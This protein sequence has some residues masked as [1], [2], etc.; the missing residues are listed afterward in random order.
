[1]AI[2]FARIEFVKR[3]DGKNACAKAAYNSRSE[4]RFEGN[5][6]ANAR[7][8]DWS[9]KE[10][11]A[12]HGVLL[13]E[14][15]DPKFFQPSILWNAVETKETKSNAVVALD[16]VLALPDEK[17]LSLDDRVRLAET[18]V[19]SQFVSKGLAA[20]I[21][22]HA[23]EREVIIT[24]NNVELGLSR[25]SKGQFVSKSQDKVV[26]RLDSGTIISFDPREFTGYVEKDHNWHAH[27]LVTTRRFKPDGKE[28]DNHKARDLMPRLAYGK[29]VSGLDW[30]KLWGEH[31]NRYFEEK[32]F[33]F[34]VDPNGI[35]PQEHLGPRR[36]RARAFSLLEEQ[37]RRIETNQQASL[38]PSK[39]LE[40]L[41]ERKSLFTK[42]D[43]EQFFNKYVSPEQFELVNQAFWKNPDVVQLVDKRT[44]EL[45][46]KFTSQK[47]VEEEK[48]ILRLCDKIH[49]DQRINPQEDKTLLKDLTSE[50]IDAYHSIIRG[51]RLSLIQGYAG[52]G[53]SYL[54]KALQTTYE[55]A[56]YKVRAFG[57]DNATVS[58]L[59]EKGLSH[60][61]NIYRFLTAKYHDH[62]EILKGK[63]VWILDEA[64]KVG[65]RPLLE[66]LKQADK[67]KVKLILSGDAA[68]LS[69]VDR[70]GMFKTLCNKYGAQT[71]I[72]I[73]RQAFE[74]DRAISKDLATG[75]FGSAIDAL[76][77]DHKIRW[78]EDKHEAMEALITRWAQ[79][80]RYFPSSS[81]LLIAHS[82]AE[83]KVLNEM[84]RLIR[85]Q[86]GEIEEKEYSCETVKGTIYVSTG[87][88]LKLCKNDRELG[89]TNG[90]YG[91]LI[92]VSPTRFVVSLNLEKG[93]KQTVTFNPQEYNDFQL[94]Y[95][96]TYHK[97]QGKTV[98]RAYVLHSP[99]MNK[100]MFYVGLTRHVKDVQYF[101]SK[102]D[103]SCLSDLKWIAAR[104]DH[105]DLTVGYT[106][107]QEVQSQ[108]NRESKS[109]AIHH[110]K[111]SESVVDRLKGH[112]LAT[113]D[114]I[115]Q[116]A[117]EIQE[118]VSDRTP[119]PKFYKLQKP[120]LQTS[121][122][123]VEEVRDKEDLSKLDAKTIVQPILASENGRMINAA[124]KDFSF[125]DAPH[126]H[127]LLKSPTSLRKLEAKQQSIVQDYLDTL[128]RCG[129][130]KDLVEIESQS[131]ALE[132]RQSPHF[133]EWQESCGKRNQAA[134]KLVQ[135]IEDN[136]LKRLFGPK[137]VTF[138]QDEAHRHAQFLERAQV[139]QQRDLEGELKVYVEPLLYRLFPEGPTS[140]DR[141]HY[142]FGNKG[143]LA[144]VHSGQKT[145][146][147]FDHE[148]QSGGGLLKLI[149][150][151]L[152]LGR[153]EAK[154]WAQNFIGMVPDM[155]KPLP[156]QRTFKESKASDTWVSLKPIPEQP[157][158]K[159]E[160]LRKGKLADFYIEESRH[161]YRD[162][163]GDPLYYVLRLK[164]KKDPTRKITPPL[165]YGYWKSNPEKVGWDLKGYQA[166]K[167]ILYNIH[168]L[169]ENYSASVLIVEGEKTADHALTK[170][171][172]EG[173]IC[174]TWS[175]GAGAVQ[176]A[177]W[178]PLSG[179]KVIIWPDND[180]AGVKAANSLCIE[181][182]R[183]GVE[184]IRLVNP[185]DLK[186]DFPKKWD[187]ADQL[188]DG[189]DKDTPRKLIA[190][191][192][193]KG[194]STSRLMQRLSLD[195]ND[196]SVKT[197]AQEVLWRVDERLR[198][199]LEKRHGI[200]S[201]KVQEEILAEA[202][203][204]I[205]NMPKAK[206]ELGQKYQ[207]N[208]T[209]LDRVY[210]QTL[211][212]EA[213]TGVSA[214]IDQVN[215][216]KH[217]VRDLGGV[218][219]AQASH[220]NHFERA[221]DKAL[222]HAY[223]QF[224]DKGGSL[225]HREKFKGE[226]LHL[227]NVLQQEDRQGIVSQKVQERDQGIDLK[228]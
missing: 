55:S 171:P 99:M 119:D 5:N 42:D 146:Q 225:K 185:E 13:P 204:L 39:V 125:E 223:E 46:D 191:S 10:S 159:L 128:Q 30:G 179:R 177:D 45:V 50:Q 51:K 154:E 220:K 152:G 19:K 100:E 115:T 89:I 151:E 109:L 107:L 153:K 123:R 101:V 140:R 203:T 160:E 98:E 200:Y 172:K 40:F 63:E 83:V 221:F 126:F 218:L 111:Q 34:R 217:I 7:T 93:N 122:A 18:F 199:S 148:Q 8:Y 28:F 201:P 108:K 94:G 37:Q 118:R 6:V 16:L 121:L 133:T 136:K 86:R 184:S 135:S 104:S 1:M 64:S 182:K 15:V 222:S 25:G 213:K 12:H 66:L 57:P 190:A 105:K 156:F 187:L 75:K 130:L 141:I 120:A 165:S 26:F 139:N 193:E 207:I 114:K 80:T 47:V 186:R 65:N 166:E 29:V 36:M 206:K 92:D 90:M 194:I 150:R 162:Q 35:V 103:V 113:W 112:G 61:E 44:G 2:S 170:V 189:I 214:K 102:K 11:P 69:P 183:V 73:Q 72:D 124:N 224:V 208:G 188:P 157:A 228:L 226:V 192:L 145:G 161:L 210:Y 196:L 24:Q 137:V 62:R 21:D 70:G 81:T 163:N 143:A 91:T 110:L 215:E 155:P 3:V 87:D 88:T 202:G 58:V 134:Y 79:D 84:V 129:E 144:V 56:G 23:P 14:Y 68:Q 211:I 205:R 20:Q 132:M 175:G 17:Q 176:R 22:I 167:T 149:Q 131:H 168:Q 53:K 76:S 49:E 142:R 216:L 219:S 117:A 41:T 147:F 158:P 32:G 197:L 106:T 97:G 38:D 27:I 212:I 209:T 169:K 77:R 138:I 195:M 96:S 95:A 9:S 164:D 59:Q 78:S 180:E 178:T 127:S 33:D 31:Q 74:K 174:L 60:T 181:L 67:N 71:L 54:L 173:F 48:Q 43:V 116:T 85:R 4:I 82:N 198:D 52:T 227:Y